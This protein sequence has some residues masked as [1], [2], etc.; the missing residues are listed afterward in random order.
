MR[1][2]SIRSKQNR[3]SGLAA[4]EFA[5]V[6]PA[7][8]TFLVGCFYLGFVFMHYTVI[9]KAVHDAARYMSSIPISE[10][11]S[12]TRI[13]G[14]MAAAREIF[15][16]ETAELQNG[17]LLVPLFVCGSDACDGLT[18]PDSV[19]VSV[20]IRVI[21]TIFGNA[22]SDWTDTDGGILIKAEVTMP[23]VGT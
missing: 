10:M 15:K 8:V 7:M 4:V 12:Q 18:V 14:A 13:D 19:R 17:D 21:D 22:T 9:H 6:L 2:L 5:L 1:H 3:E 23:Y 20:R 11:K 16:Q